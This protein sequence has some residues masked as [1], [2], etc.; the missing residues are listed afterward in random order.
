MDSRFNVAIFSEY[1]WQSPLLILRLLAPFERASIAW[2]KGFGDGLFLPE[3]LQQA[4][5]AVMQRDFPRYRGP[6]ER[7]VELARQ[8]GKALILEIDDFLMELPPEHPDSASQY[9]AEAAVPI[10]LA[11]LE[12]DAVT[13]SSQPL[14]EFFQRLNPRTYLLPNC[15]DQRRWPVLP[16]P[17]PRSEGPVRIGYMGTSS[18]LGDLAAIGPVLKNLTRRYGERLEWSFYGL[19][20]PE[21]LLEGARISIV[22][23]RERDYAAFGRDLAANLAEKPLDMVIAPL[24]DNFFNRCKSPVKFLE[25]SALGLPGVYSR[26]EPYQQVVESGVNGFLAGKPDEWEASLVRLIGDPLLRQEM[27]R[28]A[29]ETVLQNWLIEQHQHKWLEVYQQALTVSSNE[30]RNSPAYQSAVL[31]QHWQN[32]ASAAAAMKKES[33]LQAQLAEKDK[34]IS[35]LQQDLAQQTQTARHLEDELGEIKRSRAWSLVQRI[36]RLRSGRTGR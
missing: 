21:G 8:S 1:G 20:P 12:V 29:Q 28:R 9:Y 32:I 22:P 7:V 27:G 24:Q 33:T 2:E 16:P 23:A 5:L 15:L 35:A 26:L 13:V 6:Y 14:F 18:H 11:A 19:N 30:K 3:V 10:L 17:L 36:W 34:L 25:Y 31:A 4:N